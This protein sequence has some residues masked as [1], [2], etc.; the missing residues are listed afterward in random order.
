MK[1]LRDWRTS[2]PISSVLMCGGAFLMGS[3][4]VLMCG[5]D[6]QIG[7]GAVLMC[8]VDFKMGSGTVLMCGGALLIFRRCC[9]FVLHGREIGC[10]SVLR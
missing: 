7:T 6:F 2:V 5:G 1:Y 3:G 4:A 8:G 9:R 10:W